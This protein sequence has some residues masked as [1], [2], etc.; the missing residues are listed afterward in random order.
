MGVDADHLIQL[1][2][3][4]PASLGRHASIAL[5]PRQRGDLPTETCNIHPH[6]RASMMLE[7]VQL[8]ESSGR[9]PLTSV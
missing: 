9:S 3:M 2:E 1:D 4:S 8:P 5:F 6:A 7:I